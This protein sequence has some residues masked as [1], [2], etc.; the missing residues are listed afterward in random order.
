[1][2]SGTSKTTS[3]TDAVGLRWTGHPLVDHGIA[4]LTVFADCTDP[5]DVTLD[6]L[7]DF[8]SYAEQAF[9]T[10]ALEG[11]LTVLFTIN[12]TY[13]NPSLK[14][15]PEK[16]RGNLRSLLQSTL[17]P[18]EG[19]P[20][21][22]CAR[23]SSARA[24]RDLVP[25]VTGRDMV[26]FFPHGQHGLALC[27]RCL[28]ALQALALG[29]PNCEGKALVVAAD[30]PEALLPI[31]REWMAGVRNRVDLALASGE[32]PPPMRGPRTRLIEQ[33]VKVRRK[34]DTGGGSFTIYHLTNSGQGPGIAVYPL[35]S[36]VA[37]FARR[38]QGARYGH[39][40]RTLEREGWVRPKGADTSEELPDAERLQ[41]RNRFYE[42]LF[43]L[44]GAARF[45]VRRHFRGEAERL[46]SVEPGDQV[47]AEAVREAGA[48][49]WDLTELFLEEVMRME[50]DRIDSI[51]Q[52]GD[53]MADEIRENDDARFFGEAYRIPDGFRGY[54]QARRLLLQAGLRRIERHQ[55]PLVGFDEFLTVFEEGDE[56]PRADWR[57]AW[58]LVL[59][60]VMEQLAESGWTARHRDV[61]QEAIEVVGA[62]ESEPT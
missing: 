25:M 7:A 52:F 23:P 8:A 35:P 2:T 47:H 17:A 38:A 49:L 26:N 33:L 60:R 19:P 54:R 20:C 40:W 27:G 53:R 10:P 62:L 24:Y 59:I 16:K 37:E 44:P 3:D 36:S 39:S 41:T 13:L 21:A 58:D 32:K 4:T 30:E 31:V 51:R 61:V 5:A 46:F 15:D 57:L 56:L 28:I 11:F 29:A 22:F 45:F 55:N 14:K 50:R 34:G 9:F 12:V 48:S 18:A 43:G 1:M 42:D 6:D